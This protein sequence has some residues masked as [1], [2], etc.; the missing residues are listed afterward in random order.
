MKQVNEHAKYSGFL[1]YNEK[2]YHYLPDQED[3]YV[4][5]V[6]E[7]IAC[8]KGFNMSDVLN[9]EWSTGADPNSLAIHEGLVAYQQLIFPCLARR[10]FLNTSIFNSNEQ[11]AVDALAREMARNYSL[12]LE[13]IAGVER[14]KQNMSQSEGFV[15]L[16]GDM[17]GLRKSQLVEQG[18]D[19]FHSEENHPLSAVRGILWCQSA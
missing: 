17:S 4:N 9:L 19:G 14:F 2:I 1:H 13:N 10:T 5:E 15:D 6:A 8:L 11:F 12:R 16:S 3:C 18:V 7:A